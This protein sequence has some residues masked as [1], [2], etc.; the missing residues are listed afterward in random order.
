M[1]I[2]LALL[3]IVSSVGLLAQSWMRYPSISPDG[4]KIVFSY[5]GDLFIVPSEGGEARQLTSN[6]AHDY[7]PVWSNDGQKIAF[8]SNRH[9]NFDVFVINANGG[10]PTRVTMHSAGDYPYAFSPDNKKVIYK[11]SRLD[12]YQ[13]IQFPSGVLSELYEVSVDGGREKQIL[14]T[15]A[16]DVSYFDNGKKIIFHNRKGYED[17]WRKH[18][19]SSVTRDI[20]TYDFET[21]NY[22]QITNWLGEDRNPI[23]ANNTLYFLSEK[24]GSF[25]IWEGTLDNP[26]GKQLTNYTKHPVRFLSRSNDGTLCYGYDGEIYLL[27]NGTSKKVEINVNKDKIYN[28]ISIQNVS[29]MGQFSVSPNGKEIAFIY[30]GEVFVTSKDY[31][32]TKQITNTPEQERSVNFSP[33]GKKLVYAGERNNSWN[34]YEASLN[35]EDKYFFNAGMISE[36]ALVENKEETFEPQYSPD[37]KEVAFLSN[38]TTLKVINLESKKIRTVL[39]AEYNY[40]YSDGD[41][42]FTWSPDSKWLLVQFFEFER[43]VT[44]VG[45]VNANGKEAPINLTKSGYAQGGPK[46]A[47]NGEMVYYSTDYYGYRS[48]GSWGSERDI[49]AVFLTEDAYQKFTLSK[50]DYEFWKETEKEKKKEEKEDEEKDKKNAEEETVE[51]LKIELDGLEDR[52]ARLTIHASF[53]ADYIVNEEGTELYYLTRFEKGYNIWTTK[54]KEHETKQLAKLNTGGS[55]IAFDKEEKNIYVR[56]GNGVA[57]VDINT[58]APK[59]IPFKAEMELNLNAER[60]YMLEHAWRQVREKFYVEDL[61]GVD[62]DDYKNEYE[63]YLPF[64]NNGYDFAEMLAELLGELNASHTGARYYDSKPKGDATAAFGCYYDET[65][66][67]DGLKIIEIMDKSPLL[68]SDK[69]EAGVIIESIDGEKIL[70]GQNYFQLLNRKANKKVY[71]GFYN[72]KTKERWNEQ[73]KAISLGEENQL[74]Y[75]RWVKQ[76]EETVEKESNGRLGYVHV[77]GMNS[78]SFRV[79]FDKALGKYHEKEALIVDTRFNGGGWLHDDL[80]TFLSGK[81]YMTFEPRGQKNM[82]GEPIW[83]WQKPSCVLISESNY[84]D[85]HL[86]P[87]T[88]KALGIGKLIG[89]PVP[90]TGT[91]VWWEFMIDGKTRFGIPQIGMRSVSEGFLV[92][93]HDLMPDIEVNNEYGKSTQGIDQQLLKAIEEMLK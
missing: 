70:A 35:E 22:T 7:Y 20:F 46:F 81:T 87:Y 88:Y 5:K 60:A 91:A 17:E 51:P 59:P 16:E 45:L 62:W 64:I 63:R 85:A 34:I 15:A 92:E 58:G 38:R 3:S 77:R 86:F 13:S 32:T 28:D 29:G 78:G 72:P 1:K 75:E 41:Q 26:Y 71:V 39:P 9:G 6:L 76:C 43:W 56:Q 18:H 25:N 84:S 61:H 57:I 55:S 12:H 68:Q 23:V 79:L 83:K 8:S 11:S 73:I 37:G 40:S 4:Q 53:L 19:T 74:A 54:F 30:R 27:K 69:M 93:N 24:S 47:M 66:K 31:A 49:E 10:V 44:D 89:M 36:R 33:D 50:E 80:A 21:E 82:G 65:H 67:G 14:T 52:K 90:G 42:Y 2:F 48:H